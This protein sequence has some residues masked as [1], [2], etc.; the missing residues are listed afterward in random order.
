VLDVIQKSLFRYLN[1]PIYNIGEGVGVAMS[2]SPK[3]IIALIALPAIMLLK[4]LIFFCETNMI[5][6]HLKLMLKLHALIAIWEISIK[7]EKGS[8]R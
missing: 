6:P 7:W 8:L 2:H 3:I 1:L 5:K 4:K